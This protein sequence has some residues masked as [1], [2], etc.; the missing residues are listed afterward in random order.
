ML[1]C[2]L[3]SET[4]FEF[5]P[6]GSDFASCSP[7]LKKR[8]QPYQFGQDA[9]PQQ[10]SA[11]CLSLQACVQGHAPWRSSVRML[12]KGLPSFTS[13][14][15]IDKGQSSAMLLGRPCRFHILIEEH[16]RSSWL[17]LLVQTQGRHWW[18][19]FARQ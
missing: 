3:I 1:V 6:D 15:A 19:L 5:N 12:H 2:F 16:D 7:S 9:N 14:S 10:S 18:Q 17:A 4:N 8:P 11:L 13:H